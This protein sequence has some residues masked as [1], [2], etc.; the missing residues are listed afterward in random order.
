MQDLIMNEKLKRYAE[1][2]EEKL[3]RFYDEKT[4][5]M[6]SS[7]K[8]DNWSPWTPEDFSG[9]VL[10][11]QADY[12]EPNTYDGVMLY[13]NS[14][15]VLGTFL[16]AM[17]LKYADTGDPEALK[18]A[19]RTFRGIVKIYELSQSIAPGFYCKPWGGR[20]TDETS[21]DQYIYTLTGLDDYY[22]FASDTEKKLIQQ[23][24]PS[25]AEFWMSHDYI[26]N[27]L[28]EK[29]H[30]HESR[31]IGFMELAFKYS[32]DIKFKK[33]ADRLIRLQKASGQIPYD[34]NRIRR[35][36]NG[37]TIFTPY[38]EACLSSLLSLLPAL[39]EN[40]E[41]DFEKTCTG[42]Y[43]LGR[44][45]LSEDGT[46][47]SFLEKNAEEE[48]F[49]EIPV[50]E[51]VY[52]PVP[53]KYL[54]FFGVYGPYRKGGMQTLMYS[55][56]LL[57]VKEYITVPE[58]VCSLVEKLLSL[59]WE[60]DHLTWFEDPHGIFPSGIQWMTNTISGDA[61]SHWLWC[62]WKLRLQETKPVGNSDS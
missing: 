33:E 37:K 16:S 3:E 56:F 42:L 51:T 39:K 58:D 2:V 62:Y 53:A 17:C 7:L 57:L 4:G 12:Y 52:T 22:S 1:L 28:G 61:F 13:E 6:L 34:A 11:P 8:K 48:E 9:D 27:Y 47:Y 46:A 41:L 30:W 35:D 55:R 60:N 23:M 44:L 21:S 36:K 18:K 14:G 31:F 49:H 5:L 29:L 54:Q 38:P 10:V 20:L 59:T 32:R 50:S 24:I 40:P 15:M 25:M 26:W 43:Q 19:E 45:G